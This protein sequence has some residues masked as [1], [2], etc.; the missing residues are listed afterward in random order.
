MSGSLQLFSNG[1]AIVFTPSSSF[2]A[3]DVIQVFLG[4]H[5]GRKWRGSEQL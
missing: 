1:Q 2:N 3:G 5:A 4:S